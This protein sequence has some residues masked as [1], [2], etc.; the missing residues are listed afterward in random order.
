VLPMTPEELTWAVREPARRA[1]VNMEVGL[2]EAIV[3]DVADQ[4]GGLPLVQY[5]LT[6]LFERREGS[7]ITYAQYLEIGGV[8]G[9]LGRRADELYAG[10]KAETQE[11]CKHI[12]LRLITLG[13]SAEDTRRR[14]LRS[15]LEALNRPRLSKVL[16]VFGDARLL[17]FDRDPLSR[18]PTVEVAHEALLREWERL[19]A[20][21]EESRDDLR[22]QRYVAGAAREWLVA[23][24]EDSYLLRGARL[25]QIEAWSGS[26]RIA[27]SQN[28]S[29]FLSASI[30]GRDARRAGDENRRRREL[31]TARKLA[32]AEK[33]RAEEQALAAS[34]LRR[35]AYLLVGILMVALIFALAAILFGREANRSAELAFSRELAAA[36][37]I[38]L[39]ADP[40][41]SLLLAIAGLETA[42]TAEAEQAL[43]MA[44]LTSRLRQ[45]LAGHQEQIQ[46]VAYSPDGSLIA[47]AAHSQGL[48]SIWEADSGAKLHEIPVASCCWGVYFDRDGGRLAGAE[49]AASFTVAIWDVGTG[50]K[51][52]SLAL[53]ISPPDVAFYHLNPDWTQAAVTLDGGAV[54]VW[55]LG[56]GEKLFDL[57]GHSGYVEVEYSQDGSRLVSYDWPDGRIIVWDTTTGEAIHTIE[58]GEEINDHALSPDGSQVALAIPSGGVTD[59]QLWSLDELPLAEGQA[60]MVT[61]TGQPNVIFVLAYSPAGSLIASASGDGT[62]RIWDIAT[63]QQLMVLPHASRVRT[64]VFHPGGKQLLTGD[65]EGVGRVWDIS[66]QGM[67]ERLT[68]AAHEGI[69]HDA[70]TS[71]DDKQLAT[72]SFDGTAKIWDLA[73]G[74]LLQLLQGHEHRVYSVAF[75][76]D[77]QRIATAGGDNTTRIWDVATGE[78]LLRLEGHGEGMIGGLHPGVL[79]VA[80]SPD[81]KRLATAGADGTARVWDSE[82]GEQLLVLDGHDAG[83]ASLA[84]SP[85]GRHLATGGGDAEDASVRIWDTGMGEARIVIPT[86]NGERVWGLGFSPDGAYLATSGADTTAKI[87]AL[88]YDNGEA[89]LLATLASRTNTVIGAQF[90]PDGR[91][92]ATA[93]GGSEIRLWDLSGLGTDTGVTERLLLPG[94]RGLIFSPDSSQLITAGDDGM[95]RVYLLDTAELMALAQSRLTRWLTADECRRY[96][97]IDTCP[98]AAPR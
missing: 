28:E 69:I 58:T 7:L 8:R 50:E 74:E 30:A 82:S 34:G 77:G 9:A 59:I 43:H 71:P 40:E 5:A 37:G 49:P 44:L 92:L 79:A 25:A 53:P 22:L 86:S 13:E 63:G 45:R 36:S 35:R 51:L 54:S 96:L 84:F 75:H 24:R 4:P 23:G 67:S 80:Y 62:A 98:P 66:P 94:G 60:P 93:A 57:E 91:T 19:R 20:W 17:T 42:Q 31:E 87:W 16:D 33:A 12:F 78:E 38:N 11:T 1:G 81:G 65:W 83:I 14:V 2:A 18:A 73:T 72:A 61:L 32:E 90:S 89:T 55:D 27:L 97:H 48:V 46:R 21:L 3:A 95:V 68:I 70:D 85:D 76:P 47:L 39:T 64:V 29:D 52:E 26:D 10:L 15:E 56:R 6:E 88:D 41:L